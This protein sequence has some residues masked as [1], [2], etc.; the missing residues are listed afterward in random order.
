[1]DLNVQAYRLVQ[2]AVEDAPTSKVLQREAAKRGG[3]KGGRSRAASLSS[4]RRSEIARKANE[5]RWGRKASSDADG[6]R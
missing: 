2:A 1:M 5:A 3:M 4:E 6:K